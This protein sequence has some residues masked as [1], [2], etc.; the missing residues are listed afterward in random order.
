VSEETDTSELSGQGIKKLAL[1]LTVD[2]NFW[3]LM[4]VDS[5]FAS[6]S[7]QLPTQKYT[8][9][10]QKTTQ[11]RHML[12]CKLV[13]VHSWDHCQTIVIRITDVEFTSFGQLSD[14]AIKAEGLPAVESQFPRLIS[15]S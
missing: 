11:W 1:G 10:K 15:I 13:C 2:S 5:N 12:V 14:E 8:S 7:E 9:L 6:L 3:F 4:T